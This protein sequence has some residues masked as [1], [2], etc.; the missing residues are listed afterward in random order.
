V[1]GWNVFAR[2]KPLRGMLRTWGRSE[3]DVGL[4]EGR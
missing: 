2:R 4:L 1:Q 3:L